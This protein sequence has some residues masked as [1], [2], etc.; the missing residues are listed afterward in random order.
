MIDLDNTLGDRDAAFRAAAAAFLAEQV[1]PA[2]D[3]A[4][5]LT[6]DASGYA[7]RDTGR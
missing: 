5:L 7:P 3:L 1:L 2:D 6:L 4:R